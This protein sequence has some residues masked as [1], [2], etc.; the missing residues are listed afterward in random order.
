M[1]ASGH[2]GESSLWD[3]E[4]GFYY[5]VLN[6]GDHRIPM[7][8]RSMVGLTPLFGVEVIEPSVLERFPGFR[9]R[10]KWFLENRPD[11]ARNIA[12]FEQ[13]GIGDRQML[14]LVNEE[15]LRRILAR[16]LDESEF[17]S[18]YGVRAL[19]RKHL[20]Q[21]YSLDLGGRAARVGYE[22]GES[23][24]PLFGGNSNWRGPVWMPVNFLLI[25]ALRGHYRFYGDAFRV[26]CPT[27]SGRFMNLGQIA[28]ELTTRLTRLFLRDGQ[29]QRP[30]FGD[31]KKSQRDPHFKD[32][33]LFFEY[34]H[35]D[36]GKGL[37]AAHQTGW[38]ALVA[39]LLLSRITP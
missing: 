6:I 19:S 5:D 11:L 24:S 33:V 29:G 12:H 35:G 16:L 20:E 27:G 36:T 2:T 8:V 4:D 26:E 18:P 14:S 34:F 23:E 37:G 22:P 30:V 9:R 32:H 25:E 7:R 3:E 39:N 38:T 10:A 28:N 1:H 15:R 21:P 17:L 31:G 13:H